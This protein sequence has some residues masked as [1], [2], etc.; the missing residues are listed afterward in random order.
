MPKPKPNYSEGFEKQVTGK[1]PKRTIEV[2]EEEVAGKKDDAADRSA[3][4]ISS[5]SSARFYSRR[6]PIASC[7]VIAGKISSAKVFERLTTIRQ[8]RVPVVKSAVLHPTLQYG[9]VMIKD[10]ITHRNYRDGAMDRFSR[11][12][13]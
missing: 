5:R 11:I 4:P 8:C 2:V 7:R 13:A 12:L 3:F 6:M 9:A 1:A 10:Y